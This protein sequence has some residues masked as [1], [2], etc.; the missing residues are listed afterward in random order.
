[1][2]INVI[3]LKNYRTE[4]SEAIKCNISMEIFSRKSNVVFPKVEFQQKFGGAV[5][6][7]LLVYVFRW[8]IA[9]RSYG[10]WYGIEGPASCRVIDYQF[11]FNEYG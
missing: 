4:N 9:G 10:A 11:H 6:A 3:F 7:I 5:V 8:F 1:M 2:Q